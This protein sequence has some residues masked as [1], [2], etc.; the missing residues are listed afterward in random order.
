MDLA[1]DY[2]PE[3]DSLRDL[4][5]EIAP[6]RSVERLLRKVVQTL[7]DRPHAVQVRLW[8]VDKGDLCA[9]CPMRPQCP[10]Q[11]RCLAFNRRAHGRGGASGGA[12][13]SAYSN[14]RR[15]DWPHCRNRAAHCHQ[16]P[17]CGR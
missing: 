6:E 4:L 12:G 13:I 11:T 5:L 3:F 8:L 10:D 17:G 7:A 1:S 2:E 16:Q 9:T 15:H 14:R